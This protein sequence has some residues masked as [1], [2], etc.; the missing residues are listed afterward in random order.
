M[1]GIAGILTESIDLR[2]EKS[3]IEKISQTLKMRGPDARGEYITP[4]AALIHRRLCVID[5]ERGGQPMR[6]G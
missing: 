1:C 5:P 2:G 3:L 4:S 6:F